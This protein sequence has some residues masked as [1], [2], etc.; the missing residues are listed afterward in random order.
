MRRLILWGTV[1]WRFQVHRFDICFMFICKG[2]LTNEEKAR[3][4]AVEFLIKVKEKSAKMLLT[5]ICNAIILR[6]ALAE[7]PKTLNQKP[8]ELLNSERLVSIHLNTG[9]VSLDFYK[10]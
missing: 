7:R 3:F 2:N 5:N 6:D 1:K 8:V 4:A 10:S 9:P